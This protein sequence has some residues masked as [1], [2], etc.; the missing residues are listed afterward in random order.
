MVFRR[1]GYLRARLILN[2]QDKLSA[3]EDELD[4]CDDEDKHAAQGF[5]QSRA[6]DMNRPVRIRQ[7]LFIDLERELKSYGRLPVHGYPVLTIPQM[8]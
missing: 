8:S 5:L 7:D 6:A 3:M 2:Q 4:Q 1:F